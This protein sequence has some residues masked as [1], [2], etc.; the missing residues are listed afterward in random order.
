MGRRRNRL[1]C[2]LILL[3]VGCAQSAFCGTATTVHSFAVLCNL[4]AFKL[5]PEISENTALCQRV[6]CIKLL[7]IYSYAVFD[8]AIF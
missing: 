1:V 5:N 4:D 2:L 3:L 6:E 8:E 7:V